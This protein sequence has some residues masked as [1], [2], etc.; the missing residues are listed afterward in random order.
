VVDNIPMNKLPRKESEAVEFKVS[1]DKE[2]IEALCAFANTRGGMVYIGIN[3]KGVPIGT[4]IGKESIQ[5]WTNQVKHSTTPS[6]VPDI[7][8]RII[9]GKKVVLI[10]V[11]EYPVKPVAFKG[12]YYKRIGNANHVMTV[13]QVVDTHLRTFNR[14]WDYYIDSRHSIE[15]IDLDKVQ[16]FIEQ[17]N[18]NRD[19]PIQDSPLDVLKK[20]DL[21]REGKISNGCFLLFMTKESPSS[22]IELGRFETETTIKDGARIQCDLFFQVDRVLEFI[23]KHISKR[24]EISGELQ[25]REIW[26]YPLDGLREII[27]NAVVHRDYASASD[28]MVKIFNDRIS[29]YNPGK[30]PE[31]LTVK[32]LISGN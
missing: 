9:R 29:I 31:G 23:K 13:A 24:Y 26:E 12:R 16:K 3:D 17:S 6:I 30:L 5:Q 20:F 21:E 14:S 1:F 27:L 15:S 22:T 8:E 2:T 32:N 4:D 18:R 25:R 19:I 7:E 28:T 11:P 10:S